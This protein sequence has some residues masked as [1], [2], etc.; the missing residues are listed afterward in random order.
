MPVGDV[1]K[2]GYGARVIVVPAAEDVARLLPALNITDAEVDEGLR[3]LDA[4]AVAL[5]ATLA[6]ARA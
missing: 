6:G 3:R 1:V 4:A 2:A 5:E